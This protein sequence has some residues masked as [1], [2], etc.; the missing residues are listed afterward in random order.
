[1]FDCLV[2]GKF[3][4]GCKHAV[5]RIRLRMDAIVKK[6]QATV[7]LLKKDV[8]DLLA[9]GHESN[10]FARMDALICDI[11]RASCYEMINRF[12]EVVLNQLPTLQKLREC[13]EGA[14]EAVSTLIFAA[15]RFSDLPELCD[16]R[17]MFTDRYGSHMEPFVN[18][19]FVEKIQKKAFPNEKK[20]RTMQNIAEEFSV[21]WDSWT[22]EHKLSSSPAT[23]YE[24]PETVALHPVDDATPLVPNKGRK[25]E[26]SPTKN[27]ELTSMAFVRRHKQIEFDEIENVE[28]YL[29]S[30]VVPSCGNQI[31]NQ[32]YDNVGSWYNKVAKD[33]R[34]SEKQGVFTKSPNEKPTTIPSYGK[35]N[36]S[37]SNSRVMENSGN[38]NGSQNDHVE[39]LGHTEKGRDPNGS[40][41]QK[42]RT[43][44][45]LPPPYVKPKVNSFVTADQMIE[46]P[47]FACPAKPYGTWDDQQNGII[48]D[49]EMKPTA[50]CRKSQ[51]LAVSNANDRVLTE[52]SDQIIYDD[53]YRA[54]TPRER[55][56]KHKSRQTSGVVSEYCNEGKKI[57]R[58]QYEPIDD[59]ADDRRHYKSRH[60]IAGANPDYYN[61]GLPREPIES[62]KTEGRRQTSRKSA[63]TV[64]DYYGVRKS[65]NTHSFEPFD[66]GLD[67]QK[68]F[69]SRY[70]ADNYGYYYDDGKAFDNEMDNQKRYTRRNTYNE[71]YNEENTR[72]AHP[73]EPID[74]KLDN[75]QS[76]HRGRKDFSKHG[77]YYSKEKRHS[78]WKSSSITCEFYE[79]MGT[80]IEHDKL[81]VRTPSRSEKSRGRHNASIYNEYDDEDK[82]MDKLLIHYSRKGT[83]KHKSRRSRT[84]L[85]DHVLSSERPRVSA[86]IERA[87]PLS[88]EPVRPPGDSKVPTPAASIQPDSRSPNGRR[89]H[90]KLPEYDDLAARFAFL[91]KD[92][93]WWRTNNSEVLKTKLH[94]PVARLVF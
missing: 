1:M 60:V 84:P 22:F 88:P 28:P 69:K 93:V 11:N 41:D 47:S 26:T 14:M 58:H 80:A 55:R 82:I 45:M 67:I 68:Q 30:S 9:A 49:M 39:W 56:G 16:L 89:V 8:A 29:T 5:K 33:R 50:L 86:P 36:G 3:S 10:A 59:Q 87:V 48:G 17:R 24:Q 13:P 7:R 51:H 83:P 53:N 32:K 94:D 77:A 66:D 42:S 62:E 27:R 44:R 85:R 57:K 43:T 19:Q 4:V 61:D 35:S 74:E 23:K 64:E 75:N 37:K 25:E 91:K 81:D 20:M 40:V 38:R 72:D 21:K 71:Y 6:K 18:A 90:P 2:G 92:P 46:K 73:S 31:S 65:R 79:E 76:R 78:G 63:S 52:I 34:G 15:A 54:E 70:G 12:C